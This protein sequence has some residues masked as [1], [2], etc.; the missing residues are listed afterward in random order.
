[1]LS[2]DASGT[3]DEARDSDAQYKLKMKDSADQ[4]AKESSITPGDTVLMRCDTRG[5]LD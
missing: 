4:G 1:M 2:S 5:K 3:V